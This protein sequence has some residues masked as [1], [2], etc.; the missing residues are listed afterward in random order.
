KRRAV[1][2]QVRNAIN[3]VD[4]AICT[5]TE[6]MGAFDANDIDLAASDQF[7]DMRKLISYGN[8]HCPDRFGSCVQKVGFDFRHN[9]FS[10]PT[11]ISV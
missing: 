4:Q 1:A 6:E 9:D 7:A 2:L 10:S 11:V 3:P 5:D 8:H